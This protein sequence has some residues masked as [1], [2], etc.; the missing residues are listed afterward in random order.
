MLDEYRKGLAEAKPIGGLYEINPNFT[1]FTFPA[2]YAEKA[3][4]EART[5][6]LGLMHDVEKLENGLAGTDAPRY[7]YWAQLRNTLHERGDDLPYRND[8]NPPLMAGDP[9][10]NA[11]AGAILEYSFVRMW[12]RGVGEFEL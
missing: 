11:G 8:S 3:L 7:Q 6:M 4:K 5:N 10:F 12:T 1:T 9:E 2:Y